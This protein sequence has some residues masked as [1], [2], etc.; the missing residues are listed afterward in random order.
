M[1]A[2]HADRLVASMGRGLVAGLAGTAVM[3][4]FQLLEMKLS[5]EGPSATPAKAAEKVLAIQPRDARAEERL[6]NV[7]HFAYGT[8]WGAV[9]GLL[10]QLGFGRR[11]STH[12]HLL[13][14]WGAGL[15]MLPALELAPPVT[16]WS[17][18]QVGRDLL[19]HC[20]YAWATGLVY[21]W[22]DPA[23][24]SAARA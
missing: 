11:L 16:K 7:V 24:R 21:D 14:V 8:G 12:A 18:K 15:A 5:G 2:T 23:S 10:A 13:M 20:V 9:R 19:H 4:G 6:T 3:T 22:L 1:L 17:K